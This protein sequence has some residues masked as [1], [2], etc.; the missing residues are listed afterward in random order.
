MSKGER[1][2]DGHDKTTGRKNRNMKNQYFKISV[3]YKRFKNNLLL[4]S[5]FEFLLTDIVLREA[6][7]K[8]KGAG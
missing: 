5:P 1:H 3:F 6:V 4:A 7:F 8:K 2:S